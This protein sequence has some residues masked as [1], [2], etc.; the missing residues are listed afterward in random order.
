VKGFERQRA[1]ILDL[2]LPRSDLH[3][4]SDM[5]NTQMIGYDRDNVR[6]FDNSAALNA[7]KPIAF[8]NFRQAP[9][10]TPDPHDISS[11]YLRAYYEQMHGRL[12]DLTSRV[13]KKRQI[14]A[15]FLPSG[16]ASAL[17]MA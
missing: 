12:C 10:F 11:A 4:E 2:R 5:G 6:R 8:T 7:M 13:K 3:A 9:V 17:Q 14:S 1:L 16:I 15:A